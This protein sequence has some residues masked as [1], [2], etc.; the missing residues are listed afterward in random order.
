[1]IPLID[2]GDGV[3]EE[4]GEGKSMIPLLEGCEAQIFSHISIM[5]LALKNTW[6]KPLEKGYCSNDLE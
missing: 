3:G 2:P 6:R 4:E 5:A 1:V